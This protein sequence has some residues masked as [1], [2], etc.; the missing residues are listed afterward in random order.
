MA[1]AAG[2]AIC[3]LIG[4]QWIFGHRKGLFVCIYIAYLLA[5]AEIV[6]RGFGTHGCPSWR[7]NLRKRLL[8]DVQDDGKAQVGQAA[9]AGV[10]GQ[11]GARGGG[12]GETA[13][14][15]RELARGG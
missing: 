11:A 15:T 14:E 9:E 4:L 1:L 8:G 5:V 12:R 13:Q 2:G 7:R 6:E 3:G 10:A